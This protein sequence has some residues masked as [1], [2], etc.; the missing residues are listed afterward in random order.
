MTDGHEPPLGA[1]V[2]RWGVEGD[3]HAEPDRDRRRAERQ[4]Q[5][6]VERPARPSE[7]VDGG[8]R[9]G[10]D[11]HGEE[12]GPHRGGER[13]RERA[14]R[15]DAHPQPG[16]SSAPSSVRHA[17]S[18]YRSPK[19]NERSTSAPSGTS[20]SS[21][22]P[23]AALATS[24]RCRPG[25]V[26]R[27]LPPDSSM[28][29]RDRWKRCAASDGGPE[30]RELEHGQRR[31][32]ADVA[33]LGRAAPHLDLDRGPAHAAE[34]AHH[35]ERGEREQEHDAGRR[36]DRG[37]QQR[38]RDEPEPPPRRRA[39]RGRRVVEVV[40]GAGPTPPRPRARRPPG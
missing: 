6:G 38:E 10:A 3:Q 37:E 28:P 21:A 18:E 26:G 13:P 8:D 12:C 14:D 22:V 1:P 4:H 5:A 9:G 27:R 19:R 20:T 30:H 35:P 29:A 40:P 15:V 31:R 11:Q 2:D 39:E 25:R 16:R 32:A 24:A 34:H 33:E 17:S 36:R 7:R 23:I